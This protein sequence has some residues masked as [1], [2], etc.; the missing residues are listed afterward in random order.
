M[1][2]RR[3][4]AFTTPALAYTP[5]SRLVS[6]LLTPQ[7]GSFQ[8]VSNMKRIESQTK[9]D[10]GKR[11]DLKCHNCDT[12]ISWKVLKDYK[13]YKRT[14]KP[15]CPFCL[16]SNIRARWTSIIRERSGRYETN[17]KATT[18]EALLQTS[19]EGVEA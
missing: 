3:L 9:K 7:K 2:I 10:F 13:T 17:I 18:Q 16:S 5:S 15:T 1:G 14:S 12:Q 4:Q 8:K 6:N 11:K 19:S